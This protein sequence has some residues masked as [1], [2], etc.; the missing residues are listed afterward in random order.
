MEFYTIGKVSKLSHIS[1]DTLRYYDDIG[2][3]RP[4]HVDRDSGY[5]YYTLNEVALLARITE[6]KEYGFSLSE[7][8]TILENGENEMEEFFGRRYKELL[9]QK[10]R[11]DIIISKLAN[12]IEPKTEG[13]FM[14]KKIMLVDD[15]PIMRFMCKDIFSKNGY[16]VGEAE[17]GRQGVEMY[18]EFRP[19][20]VLMNYVM[21][22]LD[23]ISAA[24]AIL[25]FDGA[26]NIV[27]LS[28][29][30]EYKVILDALLAGVKNFIA[31]PFQGDV[32]IAAV[33]KAGESGL[34]FDKQSIKK[35][36]D[37]GTSDK[38]LPQKLIDEIVSAAAVKNVDE[39]VVQQIVDKFDIPAND[40]MPVE[41]LN[42][43]KV[44]KTP[45]IA[46]NDLEAVKL[47][48]EKIAAGQEEIKDLLK[49]M[50]K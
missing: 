47:S 36:R 48:L 20:I 31:K 50:V 27:M 7:I 8:K 39:A 25:E 35:L 12:K 1:A 46:L 4:A 17:N 30:S 44:L 49:Q 37:G 29:M 14:N 45:E 42:A 15:S 2:L 21:P 13:I 26:A 28:A 19:D 23:G 38:I 6:L 41:L 3:L 9:Q 18:K 16:I 10:Q 33:G 11:L 22:E 5:R 43:V 24:K 34:N 40:E 32:L